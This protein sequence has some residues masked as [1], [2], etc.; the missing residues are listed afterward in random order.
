VCSPMSGSDWKEG[1]AMPCHK[2]LVCCFS[3]SSL[4]SHRRTAASCSDHRYTYHQSTG[5]RR[6]GHD[7]WSEAYHHDVSQKPTDE[8]DIKVPWTDSQYTRSARA[9]ASSPRVLLALFEIDSDRRV[10]SNDGDGLLISGGHIERRKVQESAATRA[11]WTQPEIDY[12]EW[13]LPPP[14]WVSDSGHETVA[15]AVGEEPSIQRRL[16]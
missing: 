3:I 14:A 12:L 8:R 9:A 10:A 6:G 11:P 4:P 2:K 1:W 15:T 5:D 7:A 13:C 16:Y